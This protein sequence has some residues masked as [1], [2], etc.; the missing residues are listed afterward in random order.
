MTVDTVLYDAMFVIQ[1]L[2]SDLPMHFGNLAE[3]LLTTICNTTAVEI[4]FVCDTYVKSINSAEQL[5]NGSTDASFHITGTEQLRLQKCTEVS[6]LQDIAY[7]L[8]YGG[9]EN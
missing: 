7:S 3:L 8:P 2:S 5:A 6:K 9:M 1:S 4:H